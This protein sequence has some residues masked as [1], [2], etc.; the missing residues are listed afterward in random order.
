LDSL[1]GLT[2]QE[3]RGE[4]QTFKTEKF[5]KAVSAIATKHGLDVA[6]LQAFVGKVT[7]RMIFDD[8]YLSE[9]FAPLALD[10]R[11]RTQRKLS[12]MDD[13]IPLLEKIAAGHEISGLSVYM[14]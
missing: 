11:T 3:V 6:A 5:N 9:L 1:N 10:W 4:Y 12:F 7:H 2:E 8:E 14:N 13:M